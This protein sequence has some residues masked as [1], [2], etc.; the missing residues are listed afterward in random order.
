AVAPVRES[1][2]R[3]R[4]SF[5][6]RGNLLSHLVDASQILASDANSHCASDAGGQHIDAGSNGI[7]PRIRKTWHAHRAIQLF[8]EI[9]DSFS[10]GPGFSRL[11]RDGCLE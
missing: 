3:A 9:F 6:R 2:P 1:R 11:Q 8:D 5:E 4:N 10:R 7:S